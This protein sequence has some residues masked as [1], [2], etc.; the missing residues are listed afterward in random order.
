MR[1]LA[2]FDQSTSE[3]LIQDI[4]QMD[5]AINKANERL[6]FVTRDKEFQREYTRRLVAMSD[7]TTAQEE[8]VQKGR[9]QGIGIGVERGAMQKQIEMARNSLNEGL[10]IEVIHKITGLD[11]ETIQSL[12]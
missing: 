3:E 11:I 7:W 5:K 1:W 6:A 12:V 2:Y 8:A 4:L 9:E 10:P